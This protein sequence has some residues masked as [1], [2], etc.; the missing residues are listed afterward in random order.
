MCNLYSMTRGQQAIIAAA[1]AMR[2]RVGN[3]PLM[4]GIY[5]DYSA[6]IV[7]NTADGTV[8]LATP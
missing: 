1:R 5:P 7:R 4:P 3:L 6:P 2:D 8:N